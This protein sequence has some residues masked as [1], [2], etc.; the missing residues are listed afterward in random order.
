MNSVL[1]WSVAVAGWV[2]LLIIFAI[3]K[4]AD[5]HMGNGAVSGFL[6]GAL[7]FGG[8]YL[9]YRWAKGNKP[10]DE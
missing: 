1:K 10:K 4:D 8:A 3:W 2:V 5:A 7:V 9:L 6:R